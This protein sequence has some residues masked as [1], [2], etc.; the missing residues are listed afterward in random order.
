MIYHKQFMRAAIQF[1][2]FSITVGVHA[3]HTSWREYFEMNHLIAQILYSLQR[4][5][6]TIT[7][8]IIIYLVV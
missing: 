4:Q 5:H 8:A 1:G 7:I 3:R 6:I 2:A